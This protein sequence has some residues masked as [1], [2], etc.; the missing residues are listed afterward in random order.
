MMF[1]A[2]ITKMYNE[3]LYEDYDFLQKHCSPELLKK[4]QDAYP[5]DSDEP[6]YATW[7]FRSGRQDSK[8]GSDGKTMILDVTADG[9][10][11]TY[12]ALDMGWEF[13]NRVKVASRNGKIIIEDMDL[14]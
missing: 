6:A 10:W 8:P 2:F 5:Y 7:L 13:T 12:K 9:D 3:K 1:E 11:Y 4:L 14:T